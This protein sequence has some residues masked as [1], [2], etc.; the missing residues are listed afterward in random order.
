MA[1]PQHAEVVARLPGSGTQEVPCKASTQAGAHTFQ[2]P[3]LYSTCA[4]TASSCWPNHPHTH[5]HN[6]PSHPGDPQTHA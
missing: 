1:R 5:A 4:I 3:P 6:H 2:R